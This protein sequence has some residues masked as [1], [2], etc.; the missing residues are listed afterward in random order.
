MNPEAKL[1]PFPTLAPFERRKVAS[2]T[3][4][5]KRENI[6]WMASRFSLLHENVVGLTMRASAI[7]KRWLCQPQFRMPQQP[8]PPPTQPTLVPRMVLMWGQHISIG[9]R[10]APILNVAHW[11]QVRANTGTNTLPPPPLS[12]IPVP[13]RTWIYSITSPTH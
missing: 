7:P 2:E 1:R 9:G 10:E 6:Y 3:R 5:I 4:K 13:P 8:A 11:Y 12:P